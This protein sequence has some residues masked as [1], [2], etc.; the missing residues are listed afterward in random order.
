M[1]QNNS[2]R[3]VVEKFLIDFNLALGL[4]DVYFNAAS[5]SIVVSP[6]IK[7]GVEVITNTL[8]GLG[9]AEGP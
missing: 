9:M 7:T 6:S 1:V 8:A 5:N 4:E 2:I 3:D